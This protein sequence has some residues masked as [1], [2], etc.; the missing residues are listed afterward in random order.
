M[1]VIAIIGILAA[2][3]LPAINSAIKQGEKTR[4]KADVRSVVSAWKAYYNEYGNWPVTNGIF[5]AGTSYY[6][7]ATEGVCNGL[8]TTTVVVRLLAPDVKGSFDDD[9]VIF[10]NYNQK[11]GILPNL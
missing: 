4:A 6:S 2:I 3:L 11:N 8:L 5:L 7:N 10:K 9:K 1:I